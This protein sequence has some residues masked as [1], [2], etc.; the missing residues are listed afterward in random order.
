[1]KSSQKTRTITFISYL[2]HRVICF[3]IFGEKELSLIIQRQNYKVT[4]EYIFDFS[5]ILSH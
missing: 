1:M 3:I 4:L 2:F 5:M